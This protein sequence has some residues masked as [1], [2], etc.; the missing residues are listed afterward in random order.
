MTAEGLRG[1]LPPAPR[2]GEGAAIGIRAGG[3]GVAVPAVGA[4]REKREVRSLEDRGGRER[5]LERPA[6]PAARSQE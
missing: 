3:A 1:V 4:G 6:A 2:P 5:E